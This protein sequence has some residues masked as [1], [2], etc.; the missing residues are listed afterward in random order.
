MFKEK[1][2][3]QV[4]LKCEQRNQNKQKSIKEICECVIK[5][6][7]LCTIYRKKIV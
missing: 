4:T 3:D 1:H 6:S 2:N 7:N 5:I